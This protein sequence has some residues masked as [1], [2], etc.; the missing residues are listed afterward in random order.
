M[1][2]MIG[3]IGVILSLSFIGK[4]EQSM[5]AEHTPYAVVNCSCRAYT[6]KATTVW[7]RDV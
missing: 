7:L 1:L 6:N 5:Y 3:F 4:Y 2:R